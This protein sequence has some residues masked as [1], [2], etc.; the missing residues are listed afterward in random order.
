MALSSFAAGSAAKAPTR[1][2][3]NKIAAISVF[4]FWQNSSIIRRLSQI[5]PWCDINR[6]EDLNTFNC[7]KGYRIA[8]TASR[9]S[10]FE[11]VKRVINYLDIRIK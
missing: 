9:F 3:K 7:F 8:G 5:S 11:V 10:L 2:Q 6:L 4:I 1:A